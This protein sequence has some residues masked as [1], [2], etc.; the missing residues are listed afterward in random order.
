MQP[1]TLRQPVPES[2]DPAKHVKPFVYESLTRKALHFSI[3]EIQS[4]MDLRD[5]YALDLE[6][7][8]TMMAFLLFVPEPGQIAM[9]G[10]GGGS[11]AKFC[12]RHLPGTRI[13]VVE[14]NPHVIALRDE[15]H[16]PPDDE[17]F[18]VVPGDG[19]HYVRHRTT[20][21]DVL[22]VDGFDS[23]GLPGGLCSQRFYDEAFELLHPGGVM[24]VNL[25]FG[26][27]DHARHVERIRRS[28]AGA[29][30]VVDDSDCSNT[31]VFACKGPAIERFKAGVVRPPK[32]LSKDAGRQLLAGFARVASAWKQQF[33]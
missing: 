4:R 26:H 16:V 12:H 30:L 22:M 1:I 17:R 7:T 19:A 6:Y 25:H 8:R 23:D 3:G 21:C 33:G 18:R 31:V 2:L 9:I 13:H 14:I 20:R 24:V 5:P 27:R 10:L 15:F 32:G 11:L 29:V 28:F